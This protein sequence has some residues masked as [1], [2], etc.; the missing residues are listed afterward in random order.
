MMHT[1]QND[2]QTEFELKVEAMESFLDD[3][4]MK[5]KPRMRELKK[6]VQSEKILK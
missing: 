4:Y 6:I 1:D 3:F 5:V 2:L